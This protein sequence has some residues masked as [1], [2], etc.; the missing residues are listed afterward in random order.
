M[1]NVKIGLN[2]PDIVVNPCATSFNT[3]LLFFLQF[4]PRMILRAKRDCFLKKVKQSNNTYMEARGKRM[5]SCY[6]LTTSALDGG[7]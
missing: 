6:S 1:Y 7:D 4:V 2:L 5:Y 3:Q